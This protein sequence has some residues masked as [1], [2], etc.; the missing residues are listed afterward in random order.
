[1]ADDTT[2]W[3]LKLRYGKLTTPFTH[4]SLIADGL[5]REA[6]RPG[7]ECPVGRAYMA[8]SVWASDEDEAFDMIQQIGADIGF[9]CDGDIQLY[10]TPPDQPPRDAP[11]GY[12]IAFTP[13]DA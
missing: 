13:Y 2:D 8:M 4:F 12:G 6:L 1:M 10:D 5:V 7:F 11:F 9:V 3:K